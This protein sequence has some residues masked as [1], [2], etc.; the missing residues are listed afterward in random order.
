MTMSDRMRRAIDIAAAAHNGQTDKGGQPYIC[1]C[2]RVAMMSFPYGEDYFIV[3]ML[4]DVIE[5]T[6]M[7]LHQIRN[8]FGDTIADA[9]D[10]MSRRKGEIY[11][12]YIERCG[13]NLI[14]NVVKR[15]DLVDNSHPD[16]VK[17]LPVENQ[18]VTKRYDKAIVI[19]NRIAIDQDFNYLVSW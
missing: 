5:D 16:R 7:Q 8:K 6:D 15:K 12:D 13:K 11:F 19:L 18:G 1:H 14:A 17:Q 2:F 9:V 4:H 10:A 3:G